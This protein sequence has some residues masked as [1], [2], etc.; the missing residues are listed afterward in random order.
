MTEANADAVYAAGWSER[1][2]Y[3]AHSDVLPA[4]LHEPVRGR[5]HLTPIPG[6]FDMEGRIIK[7]GGDNRM[8]QTFGTA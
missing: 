1:A 4:K 6:Q 3:D 5:H 8:L 2:L 7:Q